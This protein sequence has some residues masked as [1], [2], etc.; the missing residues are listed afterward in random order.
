MR[1][2][3]IL[4]GFLLSSSIFAMQ[5]QE[6]ANEESSKPVRIGFFID[7]HN[8]KYC[9]KG[10]KAIT[11]D[12]AYAISQQALN[13]AIVSG[14]VL[15]NLILRK[16]TKVVDPNLEKA[17][18]DFDHLLEKIDFDL[19]D[20]DFYHVQDTQFFVLVQHNYDNPIFNKTKWTKID[21]QSNP[22]YNGSVNDSFPI[23]PWASNVPSVAK[24]LDLF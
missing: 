24:R 12:F 23:I 6:T 1:K 20:W 18:K 9:E 21:I 4:L 7:D 2:L 10:D 22:E 15:K 19:S 8:E 5:D 14:C 13:V 16:Y 11:Y 3:M 17:R